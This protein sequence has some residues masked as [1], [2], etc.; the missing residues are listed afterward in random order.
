LSNAAATL[1]LVSGLT[2]TNRWNNFGIGKADA[3]GEELRKAGL[4]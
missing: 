4:A 1:A 2:F 3:G